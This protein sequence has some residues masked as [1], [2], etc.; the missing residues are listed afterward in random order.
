M[1]PPVFQ[2]VVLS[3]DV[4]TQFGVN[5]TRVYSFGLAPQSPT[6]PYATWQVISGSPENYLGTRPDAD[7]YTIQVDVYASS[8]SVARSA[9]GALAEAIEGVAHIVSWRGEDREPDTLFFRY[10]FDVDWIVP[11]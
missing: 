5:P 2:T 8:P 6:L 1:T 10:S 9:A 4:L 3:A 7:S 11:R